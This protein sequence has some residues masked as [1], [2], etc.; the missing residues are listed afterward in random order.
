MRPNSPCNEVHHGQAF[1]LFTAS[2]IASFV[3][4]AIAKAHVRREDPWDVEHDGHVVLQHADRREDLL[5]VGTAT[6]A[7][8]A[9]AQAP[10]D[11]NPAVGR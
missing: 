9:A 7:A 4:G 11:R 1:L 2:M 5:R 6:A 8:T 3:L 10:G